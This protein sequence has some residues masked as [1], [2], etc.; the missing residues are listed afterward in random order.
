MVALSTTEPKNIVHTQQNK[1]AQGTTSLYHFI[2]GLIAQDLFKL[3][4]I[5]SNLNPYDMGTE[6]LPVNKF[7]TFKNLL[8]IMAGV[9]L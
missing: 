6:I 8:N 3:E 1:Q 7:D 4:K 2:R 9:I 5:P